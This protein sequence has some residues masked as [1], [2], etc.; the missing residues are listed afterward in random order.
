MTCETQPAVHVITCDVCKV[1]KQP[2]ETFGALP[3]GWAHVTFN[4]VTAARYEY[5]ERD[6]CPECAEKIRAVLGG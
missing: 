4:R 6:C 3:E 2:T 1:V 5:E